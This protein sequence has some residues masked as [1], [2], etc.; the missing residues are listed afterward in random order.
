MNTTKHVI[1]H[2][3]RHKSGTT[4]LQKLLCDN[5]ELL[6]SKNY[7]YPKKMRA[8][9][10]HHP[11][12]HHYNKN[13]S[14]YKG[15][16]IKEFWEEIEG[17]NNII[18]SSEGLQNINPD[19]LTQDFKNFKLTVIMYIRDQVSYLLSSYA[20]FVQNTKTTLT[21]EEYEQTVFNNVNYLEFIQKW[22]KA[23]PNANILIGIFNRD[24]LKYH[25]I[26]KDFLIKSEI[27]THDSLCEFNYEENEQNPSIGGELLEFKRHL[28]YTNFENKINTKLLYKIL[29]RLAT[30]K[31]SY[32]LKSTIPKEL[33]T[34]IINK[35]TQSNREVSK[36]YLQNKLIEMK[37]QD[38][39]SN[40][41]ILNDKNINNILRDIRNIDY[42]ISKILENIFLKEIIL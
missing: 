35:Y 38:N 17:Y 2:I 11:L 30:N 29:E 34:L 8:R 12:A 15:F 33:H 7:Y 23:F 10:A 9:Y 31:K 37:E 6:K 39:F 3:G 22:E 36:I 5:E 42:S 16:C 32:R 26:R 28:N 20:Q 25:D 21:L 4:T 13:V 18:R 40:Q 19:D 24:I 27:A 1:L 41:F 14:N